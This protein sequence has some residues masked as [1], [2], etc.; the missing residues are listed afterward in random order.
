MLKDNNM[1]EYYFKESSNMS[2]KII[3]GQYELGTE[4]Q[5]AGYKMLFGEDNIQ[6]KFDLYF[7]WYNIVHEIGHCVVDAQEISMS[8]V[9]EE[10]FV[11]EFAVAYWKHIGEENRIKELENMLKEI[12]DNIPSPVPSNVGFEE[13][14]E[15]IWGEEVFNNVM[16]Y[17]YFQLNSVMEAIK[18]D[19]DFRTVLEFIGIELKNNVVIS[20]YDGVICA[21]NANKVLNNVVTNINKLVLNPIQV[22]IELV[23]NPMIQCAQ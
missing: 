20:M 2:Y 5:Q 12:M 21:E 16:L 1:L 9:Q 11:N 15:S 23:D 10:M 13:Y 14:Y 6:Y 18:C 19:R 7:H 4:E 17:G 22:S 8:R 3:S